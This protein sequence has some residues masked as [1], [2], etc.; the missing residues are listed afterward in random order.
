MRFT[1]LLQIWHL[2]V[3]SEAAEKAQWIT[4]FW[5]LFQRIWLTVICTSSSRG[6]YMFFW[7]SWVLCKHMIQWHIFRQNRHTPKIKSE[8]KWVMYMFYIWRKKVYN[9]IKFNEGNFYFNILIKKNIL[10]TPLI[11]LPYKRKNVLAFWFANAID[12]TL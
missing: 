10:M 4:A 3:T 7:P 8:L 1:Y 9:S 5:L 6:S 11:P 2:S 12:T